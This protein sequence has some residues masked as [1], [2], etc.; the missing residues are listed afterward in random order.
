M[1]KKLLFVLCLSPLLMATTC[2]D[3]NHDHHNHPCTTEARAALN[4]TVLLNG[5]SISSQDGIIVTAKDGSYVEELETIGAPYTF[6]GAYERP[7]NYVVTVSKA[8]Y[9]PFVSGTVH[10][11]RDECHVIPQSLTADLIPNP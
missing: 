10:V 8:G 2:D 5:E 6:S 1:M 4:V 3:E 7:G 9:Q 11:V